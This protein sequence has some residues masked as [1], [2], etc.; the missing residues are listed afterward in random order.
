MKLLRRYS[1]Q[2]VAD[3][4]RFPS[5]RKFPHFNKENL[6]KSLRGIGIE[7]HWFEE[8]GGKRGYVRG[9]ERYRCFKAEGY[10]N[11]AALMQTKEWKAA[12]GKLVE[13][14][15]NKITAIMCAERIPWRCHRK[16]ISDA[17][18]AEGFTVIHI[19]DE[20]KV[21][22]HKLTK[23]ARIVRGKLVYM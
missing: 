15:S 21:F 8:L 12:F 6:K 10:R 5:S 13:L 17:L 4:R 20:N 3:V 19:I 22:Q 23:C 7:Y 2:V 11:Y 9:A 14:A 16:L 18:L 1:I